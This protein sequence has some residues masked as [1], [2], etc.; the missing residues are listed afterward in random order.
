MDGTALSILG[1]GCKA[2]VMVI[3]LLLGGCTSPYV[4]RNFTTDGCSYF[5]DGDHLQPH[6]WCR[7]CLEHDRAYW[8]GGTVAQRRQ[9]DHELRECVV[10]QSQRPRLANAMYLGVRFAG[11]PWLP[12]GF[13]WGYG[14]GYGRGYKPLTQQERQAVEKQAAYFPDPLQP[15]LGP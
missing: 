9:A 4:L 13:R 5:P 11:T 10:E 15:T 7:C 2:A 1:A 12:S 3:A 14:W 6:R 8:Q